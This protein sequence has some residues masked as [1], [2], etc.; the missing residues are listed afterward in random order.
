MLPVFPVAHGRHPHGRN[1][2]LKGSGGAHRPEGA[3][4]THAP[5][6]GGPPPPIL[7]PPGA[8]G[9]PVLPA[10]SLQVLPARLR[11]KPGAGRGAGTGTVRGRQPAAT[12]RRESAEQPAPPL[13]GASEKS[14]KPLGG[15]GGR[16]HG[17]Q[18]GA[19][20]CNSEGAAR[21]WPRSR[22]PE[23][24]PGRAHSPAGRRFASSG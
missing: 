17:V 23:Q 4:R 13:H 10:R 19:G 16:N 3:V 12:G 14:R 1:P 22:S 24:E 9:D 21:H 20:G 7:P 5:G 11:S 6:A 8:P 18:A 2:F 15:A